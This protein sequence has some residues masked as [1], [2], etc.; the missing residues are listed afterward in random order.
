M[1]FK[2]NVITLALLAGSSLAMAD[3]YNLNNA[4]TAKVKFD[5]WQC[6]GCTQATEVM[7]TVGVGVGYNDSDD[8]FSGNRFG[9]DNE[10]PVALNANLVTKGVNG[11]R[12]TVNAYQLGMDNGFIDVNASQ[13]GDFNINAN[14]QTITTWHNDQAM[15][16]YQG[17]G[18]NELTLPSN[19]V[20]ASN[21]AAMT[22]LASSL[23][24]IDL[25]LK[26]ER[27]GLG[28][29]YQADSLWSTFVDYEREQKTG[30]KTAS[31][32]FY[33]QSMMLAEPVDY[34]TD[35]LAAGIA[36]SG[37]NWLSQLSY[38]G[39]MFS[40]N[41][42]QLNFDNAFSPTFGAQTRGAM[43][44]D[45]DNQ[46]HTVAL[47]GQWRQA[48]TVINGRLYLGQMSQDQALV[49]SGYGYQLPTDAVDAKIDLTGA[50]LKLVQK[51]SSQV[52]MQASYDYYD[53]DNQTQVD[54]WTQITI[55][56]VNGKVSYNTP[57]DYT[58]QQVKLALDYRINRGM[59]LDG[60]YDY[61]RQERDYQDRETTDE[62]TLWTR[63][64]LTSF[65]QWD[66]SVKGSFGLRDGSRYQASMLT[67]SENN[68]LLRKYNLA[69]RQRTQ[70]Q[71]QISY[72]P[73]D[74]LSFDLSGRYALDDYDDTVIGLT[75][76]QDY[77]ADFSANYLLTDDVTLNAFYGYQQISAEQNG[78][79]QFGAPTWSSNIDD[80]FNYAGAGMV[81]NNLLA[82]KLVLGLD[83]SYSDSSGETQVSQ[84]VTGN[85]GDYFAKSHNVNL[86]ATYQVS[87]QSSLRMDYMFEKY[88]DNDPANSL[89]TDA[90]WNVL[91]FGNLNHDYSAH[92]VMLSFQYKL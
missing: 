88:H 16:P 63:F 35:T 47:R 59:K 26:R 45:P 62:S 2:L 92:M 80:T 77:S 33:N 14:Y 73:L 23:H 13:P 38:Q 81:Y 12:A 48:G 5:A 22:Q 44:L 75:E 86:Y 61:K 57:Y 84:G 19:W 17:I 37:D 53:R 31:G 10:V 82:D 1:K 28:L 78:S 21:T 8:S 60:G 46:A 3:G 32:S 71:M 50:T 36:L 24:A 30:L 56:D 15:T 55:N 18:G 6:K 39:S 7:G 83:Y 29:S 64:S 11:H 34:T 69:D 9:S 52:R 41:Y 65:E 76:T 91:S 43:A 68:A 74:S 20:D 70:V 42:S 58:N 87:E 4:N 67:S 79:S 40:N 85:Y 51:L 66:F 27:Y 90:I 25:E 89:S 49:T 54:A 72:A